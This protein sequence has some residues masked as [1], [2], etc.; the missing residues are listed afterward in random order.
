LKG[1]AVLIQ[2]MVRVRTLGIT[3]NFAR[4]NGQTRSVRSGRTA[5]GRGWVEKFNE[6]NLAV[7]DFWI[8]GVG[9]AHSHGYSPAIHCGIGIEETRVFW[10]V[11]C[12]KIAVVE[13]PLVFIVHSLRLYPE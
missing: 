9:R 8:I 13:Q 11:F 5:V 2:D 3:G 4:G 7:S 6:L 10:L 12:S 1:K